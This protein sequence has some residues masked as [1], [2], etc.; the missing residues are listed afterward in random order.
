MPFAAD[1]MADIRDR[2]AHVG[3]C[4]FEGPRIFFEN[5]GGALTLKSV[6]EGA[7]RFAAIPDNQG[8]DNPAS[9]AMMEVIARGRADL[10]RLLNAPAGGEVVLG[11]SGTELLFRLVRAACRAAAPGGDVVSSTLE[12]P[13]SRSPARQWAGATGRRHLMVRHDDATGTV[14]A[15]AYAALVTPAT[16][17]AT[18]VHA[19][20][21]TGMGMD[22]AAIAGAIR[23]VAP[24]CLIIVDGIQHAAHG[25]IDLSA[26]GVDGY[27]VSPYKMFARHGFGAAWISGRLAEMPHEALDGAPARVW[28]LGT[29]DAG[30]Y[31]AL[32]GVVAYL[33]WLGGRVSGAGPGRARLEAAAAAIH[34]HEADLARAMLHGTGN[35]RGLADMAGITILGGLDNPAREG[36]VSFAAEGIAAPDL[37]ARFG[38]RGIRVHARK[39]DHYSGNV[40]VP[41]GLDGC[42][43]VS[44]AHYNSPEEVARFL[45][46][47]E[48]SLAAG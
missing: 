7:A 30:A 31:A 43:R 33:D 10:C 48:E 36:L 4:P 13:A 41:L 20:P 29:R 28:E 21:V 5:A 27:V 25:A 47:V 17:V 16:R 38:A 37:V 14:T 2:F 6:A 26:A 34:A 22:V 40:L 23:A 39:P 19:S 9:R 32:S 3:E 42:V 45:E 11:E 46:A 1:L 24:D 12:H 44:L 15:E 18:I 8:R 35:H